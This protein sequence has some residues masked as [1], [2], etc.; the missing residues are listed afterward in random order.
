MKKFTSKISVVLLLLFAANMFAAKMRP[1][2]LFTAKMDGAQETPSVSGTAS[3][4]A[5]FVLNATKDTLCV[6]AIFNGL[7]GGATSAHIHLAPAG[8]GGAVIVDLSS[9]I[10]GNRLGGV[11]TGTALS[12]T[13]KSSM[14]KGM[15][16]INVHTVA[17]PNGEIRGQIWLESETAF[18]GAMDGAQESPSVSTTANGYAVFNLAKDE[19][20][21][22]FYV[23]TNGL[24]GAITSAHLHN[25]A[26]GVAGPVTQDLS[27][28]IVN[29]NILTGVFTPSTNV[30][31][32]LKS[33]T[34]YV[35]VHTSA[36]PNGEIR[37][38][39]KM[40]D[41]ICFDAWM[42]GAQESPSVATSAKGLS[43][44]KL[45]TT[46]DSLWY[47]VYTTNLSGPITSAHIHNG[48]LGVTG[49]IAATFTAATGNKIMGVLTGT[50]VTN[51]L[52]N[53]MLTGA[54][55]VNVH[56]SANPNGE[57]RGQI[58]RV[59]REGYTI[60]M[61]GNQETP[62]VSTNGN[63]IGIVSVNRDWDNAH[64]MIMTTFASSNGIHFHKAAMGV[65]GGV[66]N[67]ISSVY[68]N[69]GAFGYWRAGDT[70]PFSP[71]TTTRAN[72]MDS[73]SLYVNLHTTGNPNGEIRGQVLSGFRCYSIPTGIATTK[74]LPENEVLVFPNP[75]K[76]NFNVSIVS[77]TNEK[78]TVM[79]YDI[80]GK[81]IISNAHE[82]RAGK[83]NIHVDLK[84]HSNGLYFVKIIHS[85]LQF[86][87]KIVMQ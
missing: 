28:F 40:D 24:S 48:A 87:K 47:S 74:S 55:Y 82:I 38:Q 53:N 50:D 63:G 8:I 57:I 64:Y 46:M 5:S 86:T 81:A 60:S 44:L 19:N 4:L 62:A 49:G 22:K 35:N 25:G 68:S 1:H 30:I 45:N 11:I 69:N 73:D 52:I 80:T 77:N 83:N 67:D 54:T 16:Y 70:S 27:S 15:T 65:S 9:F 14:L 41:K 34:A 21:I 85:D 51:V 31:S 59:M 43:S 12:A 33:G 6:N 18:T 7:T 13:L 3:G 72:Q 75:A 36:N 32:N 58:Y 29:G 10:V 37:A 56:T 20:K 39:L 79:V 61:D 17:N 26:M 78:I 84:D 66:I 76:N 42:D 23:V 71:F 2:M